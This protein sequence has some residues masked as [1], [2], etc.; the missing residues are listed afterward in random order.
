MRLI[1]D[2]LL[3]LL[4]L[5]LSN[6]VAVLQSGLWRRSQTRV[7][8]LSADTVVQE[9]ETAAAPTA[10]AGAA[11]EHDAAGPDAFLATGDWALDQRAKRNR[12]HGDHCADGATYSSNILPKTHAFEHCPLGL[13][14]Q[15]VP[16]VKKGVASKQNDVRLLLGGSG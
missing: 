12:R 16:E 6:G 15:W 10:A 5:C 11:S 4:L 3:L 1:L 2:A 13:T 9:V 8:P 7:E 14:I